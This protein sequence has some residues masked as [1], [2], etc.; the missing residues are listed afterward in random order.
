MLGNGVVDPHDAGSSR[1]VEALLRLYGFGAVDET[2]ALAS[3]DNHATV[4][5][6]DTLQP[7]RDPEG[8]A[9]LNECHLLALPWPKTL[10]EGALD[11]TVTMRVTLSYFIEPNPGSRVWE[12]NPK[13]HYPGC[14]LRLKVKHRDM[15]VD[16]F[17]SK[18]EV[19]KEDDEDEED[20]VAA[21][22]NRSLHDPGWAL[23]G[24]LR[25]K[26]GSLIQDVWRG[27]AAQLA[28]MGHIAV[29]PVKGWWA[30]R[31]FPEGHEHHGCHE[32]NVR[33]S[34]IVS[35]EAEDELPIYQEVEAAIAEIEAPAA[36][37]E[38]KI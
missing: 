23:G 9:R 14:L 10:L 16:E 30:T 20:D 24:R 12:K 35:I 19:Q 26:G 2:R 32:R 1:A 31:K 36:D 11:S 27:S 18:L 8:K 38:V 37:V 4:V 29:Y 22:T 6:E 3:F 13:Y 7:Y 15:A 5:F 33:Y 34:L 25:G 28:E 17:R 21:T